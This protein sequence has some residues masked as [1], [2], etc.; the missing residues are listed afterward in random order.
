MADDTESADRDEAER[1][2]AAAEATLEQLE[3]CIGYLHR[4]NKS[5]LASALARNQSQIRKQLR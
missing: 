1:Y 3:W 5:A 4:I 2:R